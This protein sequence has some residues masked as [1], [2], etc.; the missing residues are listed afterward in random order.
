M[1]CVQS[2]HL[3]EHVRVISIKTNKERD[4][5]ECWPTAT[6]GGTRELSF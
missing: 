3:G 5:Q 1:L 4:V 6:F 2:N